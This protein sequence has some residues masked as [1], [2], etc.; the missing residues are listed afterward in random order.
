MDAHRRMCHEGT[1]I[2]TKP[3]NMDPTTKLDAFDCYKAH[4][5]RSNLAR[6]PQAQSSILLYIPAPPPFN[7][8]YSPLLIS[9]QRPLHVICRIEYLYAQRSRSDNSVLRKRTCIEVV[10]SKTPNSSWIESYLTRPLPRLLKRYAT[11][12]RRMGY[13]ERESKHRT[14]YLSASCSRNRT[15]KPFDQIDHENTS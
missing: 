3:V 11:K 15:D 13:M 2:D 4:N 14:A 12:R 6:T 7:H 5:I 1:L 10:A 9:L 8:H